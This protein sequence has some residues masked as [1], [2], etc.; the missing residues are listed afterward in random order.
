MERALWPP[1]PCSP[2][3]FPGGRP[4]G[5]TGHRGGGGDDRGPPWLPRTGASGG[6]GR[7]P[8]SGLHPRPLVR[9]P[10]KHAGS[11]PP[12][13][14]PRHYLAVTPPHAGETPRPTSEREVSRPPG[15]PGV[16]G[17]HPLS[18]RPQ[19]RPRAPPTPQ[20]PS[21]AEWTPG[22]GACLPLTLG[23]PWD[24]GCFSPLAGAALGAG[25][26]PLPA[27]G[28]SGARGCL[29]LP[30]SLCAAG[31]AQTLVSAQRRPAGGPPDQR[32]L[33]PRRSLP[34]RRGKLAQSTWPHAK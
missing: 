10:P 33:E 4:P 13:P 29:P 8:E 22:A 21:V 24:N 17:S 12:G 25:A 6:R 19:A 34:H 14:A 15:Q 30:G 3:P 26:A 28:L 9:A 23:S 32:F 2:R 31:G 1:A 7:N 11:T 18:H 20:Y 5:W 27:R 16:Q